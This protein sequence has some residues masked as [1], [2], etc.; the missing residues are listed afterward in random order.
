M[1]AFKLHIKPSV[2]ELHRH[3]AKLGG[4]RILT[5]YP[6]L[7]PMRRRILS[8]NP[9]VAGAATAKTFRY[10]LFDGAW[11]TKR[12]RLS[13]RIETEAD[14]EEEMDGNGYQPHHRGVAA[15]DTTLLT[16]EQGHGTGGLEYVVL[17]NLSQKPDY[18]V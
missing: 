1:P 9:Y 2:F 14:S 8:S 6:V 15:T 17:Q 4:T 7:G 16:K 11:T 13:Y 18:S 12:H 3:I 10:D 5:P